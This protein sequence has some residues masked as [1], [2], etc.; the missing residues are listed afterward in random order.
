MKKIAV[1]I[2]VSIYGKGTRTYMRLKSKMQTSH[3]EDVRSKV[4]EDFQDM[5]WKGIEIGE[6][7]EAHTEYPERGMKF[8]NV[9]L[10][11]KGKTRTY[12]GDVNV[13]AK[14][15]GSAKKK[16]TRNFARNGSD[17]FEN[18]SVVVQ[19]EDGTLIEE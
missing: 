3:P 18:M 9:K 1:S 17:P 7:T 19:T 10:S 16:A 12:M 2:H 6:P 15:A 8:W 4:I 13:F 5:G 14:T 11:L